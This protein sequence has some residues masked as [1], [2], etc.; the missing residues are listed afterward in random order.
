M[1]HYKIKY[2]RSYVEETVVEAD[3]VRQ[4][5][6]DFYWSAM[7]DAPRE[8]WIIIEPTVALKQEDS[9]EQDG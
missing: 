3:S 4:A 1:T 2:R 6:A 5:E 8:Q 9:D 7:E